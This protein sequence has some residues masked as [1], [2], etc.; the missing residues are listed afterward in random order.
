VQRL[1]VTS[2]GSAYGRF[3]RALDRGNVLRRSPLRMNSGSRGDE[4]KVT[5]TLFDSRRSLG[6]QTDNRSRFVWVRSRLGGR[7][8]AAAQNRLEREEES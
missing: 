6:Q 4:T 8:K 3:R 7:V 5:D 1:F 2:Q